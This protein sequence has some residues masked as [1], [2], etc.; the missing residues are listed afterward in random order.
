[1]LHPTFKAKLP[2]VIDLIREKKIKSAYA[3]GSVVGANFNDNSDIDLMI[4]FE[5]GLEALE[6]GDI[7]WNLHDEL[8]EVFNREVDILIDGSSKNPYFIQEVN[9]KRELIYAA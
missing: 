8:R 5:E 3:F 7:Y 1:M 9:E 2:I 6:K 4:V